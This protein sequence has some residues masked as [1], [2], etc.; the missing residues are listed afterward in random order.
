MKRSDLLLIA[1]AALSMT[2]CKTTHKTSDSI[3]LIDT[4]FSEPQA[5]QSM[6]ADEVEEASGLVRS[7]RNPGLIWTHNDSG[8]AARVFLLDP[9]TGNIRLEVV[10]EGTT[11]V[12]FEDITLRQVN[13][14]P[15]LLIGDIGD[16]R[17]VRD[18]LS[19]YQIDEPILGSASRLSIPAGKIQHMSIRYTEGARD[20]ETLMTQADGSLVLLTKREQSIF[21]Y[22]FPFVEGEATLA[23]TGR[24]PL[25][26]ITAG[27]INAQGEILLRSYNEVFYWPSS[28]AGITE[29]LSAG[30][31][32]RVK[33]PS[34]PQGEAICWDGKGGFYTLS[35][36]VFGS[37]QTVHHSKSQ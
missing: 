21:I 9:R 32:F 3:P 36:S 14:E 8:D 33:A 30:P 22:Q 23:S 27:D 35:E 11:N 34:E 1:L 31:P 24:V 18:H 15:K 20:A 7:L 6:Q 2:A 13:G 37:E 29:R 17:G 4:R 10:L 19:I 28:K 16:N 25:T 26:K 12:D 5:Y